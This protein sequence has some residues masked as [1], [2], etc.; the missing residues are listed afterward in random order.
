[1]TASTGAIST[2]LLQRVSDVVDQKLNGKINLI[3]CHHSTRRLVIQ[4][5]DSDR[6]YMGASLM[7]P[8]P[9]TKA[10]QQG[11]IPFGGVPVRA[12]RDFP[13]DV[14][15]FLDTAQAEFEE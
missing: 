9:A 5:T 15:M 1:M 11:D 13:L 4:L 2:D 7:S 12:L 14:M 6:R 3:I 8:D 10:F